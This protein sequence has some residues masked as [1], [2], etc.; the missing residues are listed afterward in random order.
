MILKS[1]FYKMNDII[2]ESYFSKIYLI[3][4]TAL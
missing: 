2:N 1:L 3:M 4:L